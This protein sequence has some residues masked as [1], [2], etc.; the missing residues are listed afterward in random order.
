MWPP[1]ALEFLRELED[2]TRAVAARARGDERIRAQLDATWPFV[3]WLT[4][5]VGSS[6]LQRRGR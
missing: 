1:E 4:E 5:Q 6:Q 2:H 3:A